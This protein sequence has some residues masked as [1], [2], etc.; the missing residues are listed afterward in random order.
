[1][2]R[3]RK[4]FVPTSLSDLN[5]DAISISSNGD[6]HNNNSNGARFNN[7]NRSASKSSYNLASYPKPSLHDSSNHFSRSKQIYG[8]QSN[9]SSNQSVN[10]FH[11]NSPSSGLDRW[12]QAW[13][14]NNNNYRQ[15]AQYRQQTSLD[16][17][18]PLDF[19][20]PQTTSNRSMNHYVDDPFDD[21]WSGI[22]KL[23]SITFAVC[24]TFLVIS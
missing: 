16:K 17:S 7:L 11:I 4:D 13:E 1:M 8:S 20:P 22:S 12:E 21:P 6:R 2:N 18:N 23:L 19:Q 14:D 10:N 15:S 5:I 9:I 24:T 3:P